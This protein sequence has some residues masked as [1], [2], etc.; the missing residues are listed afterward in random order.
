MI[1]CPPPQDVF[2]VELT[3]PALANSIPVLSTL[4]L[5]LHNITQLLLPPTNDSHEDT[6]PPC[7]SLNVRS[8]GTSL[9]GHSLQSMQS[10]VKLTYSHLNRSTCEWH[11]SRWYSVSSVLRECGGVRTRPNISFTTFITSLHVGIEGDLAVTSNHTVTLS[12]DTAAIVADSMV[13]PSLHI[14][15]S[16]GDA[17]PYLFPLSIRTSAGHTEMFIHLVSAGDSTLLPEPLNGQTFKL[18]TS[19]TLG[20]SSGRSDLGGRGRSSRAASGVGKEQVWLVQTPT[21][22]HVQLRLI[23]QRTHVFSLSLRAADETGGDEV[24]LLLNVNVVMQQDKL[25]IGKSL[26]CCCEYMLFDGCYGC[27]GE[28]VSF[29]ATLSPRQKLLGNHSL[30]IQQLFLCEQVHSDNCANRLTVLVS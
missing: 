10:P 17:L 9:L 15:S 22:P 16:S 26:V 20:R 27:V 3:L 14:L 4:P 23:G 11:F 19:D 6:P 12:A 24:K 1:Q 21:L 18:L 30:E 28:G 13:P 8:N 2:L 25:T 7:S 5:S 29:T